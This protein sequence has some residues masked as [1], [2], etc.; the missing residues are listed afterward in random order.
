[1][2]NSFYH[3]LIGA[4]AVGAIITHASAE[5]LKNLA[6]QTHYHGIAFSQSGSAVLLLAS[7]HGVFAVDKNGDAKRVSLVQDF[8]GFSPSIAAPLT[9][10]ASGHPTSGGN[11]GFLKS[12]DGGATWTQISK[13]VNGPVDFHQMDVSPATS[14]TIYGNY[15]GLQVS[16]D[17]GNSWAASGAAP[18][19]LIAIAA[20]S[21]TEAM[22]YAA[23]KNG[24]QK[25]ID[26]GAT[27]L[28][29]AFAGEIVSMVK[30]EADGSVFAFVVGRGL[31]KANEKTATDWTLLADSFG[32]AVPLHFAIDGADSK[33]LALITQNNDVLES[34]DAGVS[35]AAFAGSN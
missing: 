35:W 30:T 28:P 26:G 19:G 9:Y 25:T 5:S 10:F 7:H 22:V 13:G 29:S 16:H 20:S 1:M 2:K 8:M 6:T 34:H 24:L 14:Q 4:L 32:D 11:A 31:M 33:H 17:G 23:T 18:E 15:G 27:W 12:I 21:V 3:M